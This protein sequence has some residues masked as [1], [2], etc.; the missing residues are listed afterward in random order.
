LSRTLLQ[1][2]RHVEMVCVR[3]FYALRPRLSPQESFGESRRNGISALY[4]GLHEI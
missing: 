4:V 1:T 2:S 3:D